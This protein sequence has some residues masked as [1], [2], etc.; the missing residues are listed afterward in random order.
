MNQSFVDKIR[1]DAP[2]EIKFYGIE[3][4]PNVRA[5]MLELRCKD[6]IRDMLT[7]S[8]ISRV[9]LDE[10]KNLVLYVSDLIITIKGRSLEQ[11][12]PYIQ[13]NR[14]LFVQEDYS[15]TDTTEDGK[16]FVEE[17]SIEPL[18]FINH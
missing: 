14:L 11:L 13:S 9:R 12:L 3:R 1:K 15:G 2:D 5:A 18:Q 17:I 8:Y 10:D 7:Y 16:L 4:Q 6:G